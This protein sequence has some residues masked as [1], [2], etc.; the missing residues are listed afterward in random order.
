MRKGLK[1]VGSSLFCF[2]VGQK[3]EE[4]GGGALR[5]KS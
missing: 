3:T 4:L 2:A 5:V 1:A